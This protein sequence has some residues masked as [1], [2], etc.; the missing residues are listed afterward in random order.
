[1]NGDNMATCPT[2]SLERG[3]ICYSLVVDNFNPKKKKKPLEYI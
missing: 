2:F 1:M 3:S